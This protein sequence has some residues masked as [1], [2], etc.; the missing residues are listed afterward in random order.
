MT[1]KC[2]KCNHTRKEHVKY[3][4]KKKYPCKVHGC[5]CTQYKDIANKEVN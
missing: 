1:N 2:K 4:A 5:N 3:C